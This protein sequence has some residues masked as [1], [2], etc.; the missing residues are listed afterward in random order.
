MALMIE[1]VWTGRGRHPRPGTLTLTDSQLRFV[2]ADAVAFDA[3]LASLNLSWPWY[4]FGCQFW[5]HTGAE[6]FFISFV[7]TGNTL[8][9]WWLGVQ[10]GR[11]WNRAMRAALQEQA[12]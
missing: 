11:E 1:Q 8:A 9:T 5:A 2:L 7:G 10:T 12:A 4:G 6:A 3:P